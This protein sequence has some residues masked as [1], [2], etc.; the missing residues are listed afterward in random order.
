MA[1]KPESEAKY[2][3]KSG[4]LEQNQPQGKN[5]AKLIE[6]SNESPAQSQIE[7]GPDAT[8][9]VVQTPVDPQNRK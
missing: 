2:T 9:N 5:E 1:Q 3:A 7:G 4:H 8:S 6:Q